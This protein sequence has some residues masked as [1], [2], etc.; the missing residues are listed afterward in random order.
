VYEIHRVDDQDSFSGATSLNAVARV[1]S[2]AF[3]RDKM[4]SEVSRLIFL[5]AVLTHS[6]DF[7]NTIYWRSY[8][9]AST[10]NHGVGCRCC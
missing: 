3:P 6:S 7:D 8:I 9:S 1:A 4:M 5:K 2:P 10:V